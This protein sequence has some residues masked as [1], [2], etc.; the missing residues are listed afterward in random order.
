MNYN[1]LLGYVKK[2]WKNYLREGNVSTL[3]WDCEDTEEVVIQRLQQLSCDLEHYIY[4]CN[5]DTIHEV[6]IYLETNDSE[7]QKEPHYTALVEVLDRRA[8]KITSF[9]I[10]ENYTCTLTHVTGV[11]TYASMEFRNLSI[12]KTKWVDERMDYQLDYC[13]EILEPADYIDEDEEESTDAE[14]T[15]DEE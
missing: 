13:H 2:A 14:E 6:Y 8:N 10:Q 7:F 9:W 5:P 15:K 12:T 3:R 1:V 4:L 11:G